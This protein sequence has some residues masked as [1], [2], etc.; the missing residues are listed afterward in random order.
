MVIDLLSPLV[1][2]L[3]PCPN[4]GISRETKTSRSTSLEDLF[5][6]ADERLLLRKPLTHV[7]PNVIALKAASI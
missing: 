1:D 2:F 3:T 7:M 6:D 4:L 5:I